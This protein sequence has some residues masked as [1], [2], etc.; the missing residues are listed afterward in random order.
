M[1]GPLHELSVWF[2]FS[3]KMCWVYPAFNSV[4]ETSSASFISLRAVMLILHM[5]ANSLAMR[6][7]LHLGLGCMMCHERNSTP[8]GGHAMSFSGQPFMRCSHLFTHISLVVPKRCSMHSGHTP[9]HCFNRRATPGDDSRMG[10]RLYGVRWAKL[11][12]CIADMNLIRYNTIF[13]FPISNKSDLS[14]T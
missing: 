8:V 12:L 11:G 4:I 13:L 14:N 1:A 2:H 10:L 9:V 6:V 3:K 7:V 5:Q